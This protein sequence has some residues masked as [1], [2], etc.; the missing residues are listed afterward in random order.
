MP[1]EANAL[2]T[3]RIARWVA[4]GALILFAA[5]L[6]FREGRRLQPLTATPAAA[7]SETTEPPQPTR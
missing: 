6:Y 2:P 5:A 3:S 7:A 4:A 1:Q